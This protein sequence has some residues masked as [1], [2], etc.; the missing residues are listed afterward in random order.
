LGAFRLEVIP[1]Y[2]YR[3]GRLVRALNFRQKKAPI[4]LRA[5]NFRQKKA[6][7]ILRAL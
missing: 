4:I 5:S 6:L 7:E 3:F 2:G 1:R